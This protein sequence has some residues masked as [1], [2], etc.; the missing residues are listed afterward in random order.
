MKRILN[1]SPGPGQQMATRGII[2]AMRTYQRGASISISWVPGHAGVVGNE[3]ADQWAVDAATREMKISSGEGTG[4]TRPHPDTTTM[5]RSFLKATLRRKA[6]NGWRDE[7]IRRGKSRRPYR[8]PKE[9]EVPRI[10]KAL[11]KVRK[12]LAARFFQLASG[13]AMIAP[14]LKEKFGWVESDQ[15]W[16][17]CC[18]RQP[19][20]SL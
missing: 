1:D 12:D 11:Q 15:C 4:L 5:S 16:W 9:G 6:I 3:I 8:I 13:H 18:G 19:G 7:I 17:C 14:F 2:R 20:A 10:P